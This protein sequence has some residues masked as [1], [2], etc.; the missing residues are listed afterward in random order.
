MDKMTKVLT[1]AL[2]AAAL[3]TA[4]TTRVPTGATTPYIQSGGGARTAGHAAVWDA[5][6]KLIDGGAA[7]GGTNGDAV[8][9]TGS[10][11]DPSWLTGLDWAKLLNV[12]SF[13]PSQSGQSGK[14]LTTDGSGV[15]W[16]TVSSS[17][18]TSLPSQSGQNGKYLT[19]DGTNA[20]WGNVNSLPTQT[21][22]SGRVLTTDG[23]NASWINPQGFT[24][25]V[26]SSRVTIGTG[27]SAIGASTFTRSSSSYADSPV[28]NGTMRV[29]L[30]SGLTLRFGYDSGITGLTCS[31][32]A[33]CTS[34]ITAFPSDSLPLYSC[35]VSTNAFNS[36][37]LAT[38]GMRRDIVEGQSGIVVTTTSGKYQIAVTSAVVQVTPGTVVPGSCTSVSQVFI[39]TDASSGQKFWYCNGS[40]YEQVQSGTGGGGAPLQKAAACQAGAARSRPTS[41][42]RTHRQ[43]LA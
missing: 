12:P 40:T 16:G 5:N 34:A 1:C 33:E 27:I 39:K 28:G 26:I 13:Y 38:P 23:T 21:G 18:G 11:N 22:N 9:T 14:Y 3:M 36:C 6:G 2:L 37:A 29:Y 31:T 42:P 4:Q 10:Y 24:A 7:P 20:S 35:T 41:A 19:T 25:T 32:V 17:P 30:D 8:L 15:S 43:R